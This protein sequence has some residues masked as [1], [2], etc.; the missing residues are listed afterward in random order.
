MGSNLYFFA[1]HSEIWHTQ[2]CSVSPLGCKSEKSTPQ[3]TRKDSSQLH[4]VLSHFMMSRS[5]D[6][7]YAM[8]PDKKYL[9][10]G[11]KKDY[12]YSAIS[13]CHTYKVCRHGSQ[14][15]PQITPCL[16]FFD[17]HSPDDATPNW[18]SR[19]SIAAYYSFIDPEGMKGWVSLVGWLVADSLPT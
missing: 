17:K 14:F 15:Y 13:V 5:H 12:L 3:E 18:G 11:K 6:C 2:F 19:H 16:P 1:N 9:T 10:K 7:G 8:W 4:L